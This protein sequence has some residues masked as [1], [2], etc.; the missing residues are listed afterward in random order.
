[1]VSFKPWP[2]LRNISQSTVSS[3]RSRDTAVL[4]VIYGL[5]KKTGGFIIAK[6][7]LGSIDVTRKD[8]GDQNVP[9]VCKSHGSA[10]IRKQVDSFDAKVMFISPLDVQMVRHW[11]IWKYVEQRSSVQEV[12]AP[13]D[14][15]SVDKRRER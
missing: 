4:A 7:K 9:N 6:L 8:K 13:S 12:P 3:C 10:R 14:L 5:P 15:K 11:F 2:C 1:M